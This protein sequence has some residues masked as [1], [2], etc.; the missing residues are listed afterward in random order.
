MKFPVLLTFDLDAELLW[1]ARD[2]KNWGR[3]IALS[4][5]AYGYREGVPRILDL[6]N[7]YG[8]HVTFF[9]PGMIFERNPETVA[10]IQANRVTGPLPPTIYFIENKIR[11]NG[12]SVDGDGIDLDTHYVYSTGDFGDFTWGYDASWKLDWSAKGGPVSSPPRTHWLPMS[13]ERE[14][15]PVPA[16]RRSRK[17][18]DASC[19]HCPRCSA[20]TF[21][22]WAGQ[23]PRPGPT[24]QHRPR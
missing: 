7:R 9:I 18:A 19:C 2:P 20:A 8:I 13:A 21:P 3:P 16:A 11:V 6:L 1:T 24:A 14:A 12:Y 15:G 5:G 17:S 22:A 10:A 4:Q 23:R